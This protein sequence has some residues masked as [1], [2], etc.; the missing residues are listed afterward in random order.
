MFL[1]LPMD[2]TLVDDCEE[3]VPATKIFHA[4]GHGFDCLCL[5]HILLHAF[6]LPHLWRSQMLVKVKKSEEY[7]VI[8]IEG[9]H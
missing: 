4:E 8:I 5:M 2:L 3:Y 6:S 9:Q 1:V 7:Q